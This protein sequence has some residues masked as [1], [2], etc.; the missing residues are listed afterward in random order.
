LPGVVFLTSLRFEAL[1]IALNGAAVA[2][3]GGTH[4]ARREAADRQNET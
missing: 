4:F 1:A 3:A 2:A